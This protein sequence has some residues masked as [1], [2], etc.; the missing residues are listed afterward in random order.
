MDELAE[1]EETL[2]DLGPATPVLTVGFNRRFSPAAKAV[3]SFLASVSSPLAVTIR[4]NAGFLPPEHWTQDELIGGG[5]IIGEACHAI[6][7]ATYLTGG[8]V[9]RVFAE[10]VGGP[11]APDITHDQCLI[12][13]RHANGSI[14]NVAYL[15]SGD[16]E[17]AKERVEVFGGGRLAVIDDFREAVLSFNGK[18]NV[19]RWTQDKGH[20]AEVIAF[21]DSI[22]SCSAW[23]ISWEELKATSMAAI[24]A[25]QSLREGFPINVESGALRS[26]ADLTTRDAA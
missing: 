18:Q 25:V 4:F 12:T 23:P 10:A 15:S 26:K 20:Q 21:A 24:L 22:T 5:R 13:L 1:I 3:K 8:P 17:F 7:L 9:T 11:T 16:K 2:A 19:H 14:S 6:D